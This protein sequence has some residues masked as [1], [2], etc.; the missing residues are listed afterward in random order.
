MRFHLYTHSRHKVAIGWDVS[1]L[2]KLTCESRHVH[3][4]YVFILYAHLQHFMR[5]WILLTL[6]MAWTEFETNKTIQTR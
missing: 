6:A 1:I 2:G 5:G 4:W 3:T